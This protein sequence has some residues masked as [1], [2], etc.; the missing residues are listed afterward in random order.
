MDLRPSIDDLG[1]LPTLSW[2]LREFQAQ[3][4]VQNRDARSASAKMYSSR[5][6]AILHPQEV[7]IPVIPDAS[8]HGQP[9][10]E[11][12]SP[13]LSRMTAKDSIRAHW[14]AV[15]MGGRVLACRA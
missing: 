5:L 12:S 11:A 6:L 1:L 7:T 3:S 2:F 4:E 10:S 8:D 9:A 14:G 15:A 13:S